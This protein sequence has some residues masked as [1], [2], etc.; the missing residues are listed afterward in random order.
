M[1]APTDAH[2]DIA[3]I[4]SYKG[5]LK[6][7]FAKVSIYIDCIMLKF[8]DLL[9]ANTVDPDEMAHNDPFIWIY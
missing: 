6:N 8:I 9:W 7:D 3:L 4:P 5:E 1:D 2:T